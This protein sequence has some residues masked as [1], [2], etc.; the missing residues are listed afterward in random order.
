MWKNEGSAY[1][2]I[3]GNVKRKTIGFD[4]DWTLT[5]QEQSMIPSQVN[6]IHIMPGRLEK[7]KFLHEKGW[8]FIVFT[9]QKSKGAKDLQNKLNRVGNFIKQFP[10]DIA[11]FMATADDGYRKPLTDM[12]ALA[13]SLLP[14]M[15]LKYYVGDAAGRPQDF[16]DSDKIFAKTSCLQFRTPEQVFK[17]KIPEL[18][19]NGKYLVM[20][21]GMPGSG[22]STFYHN[23][24]EPLN[25]VHINQDTLGTKAKMIKTI[26]EA[27]SEE[28]L[29][30][31]D[32]TN[33]DPEKRKEIYK[34]VDE[35]Y[36]VIV[37]YIVRDG[38]GWNKLRK[39]PVPNIAYHVFFKNFK[40]P[41]KYEGG[42]N[43]CEVYNINW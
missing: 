23:Y 4:L 24:L 26:K 31:V 43:P 9:N 15:F 3:K 2:Y 7:L 27:V 42:T 5:H 30:C 17:M 37:I 6:D 34:L 32:N 10:Y 39:S 12:Y 40:R 13:T 25:Y 21:V 20:L 1:Y 19:S 33:G 8:S 16:S 22:K 38:I 41:I 11:V 35:S 36:N 14:D 18:P 29:I 28:K